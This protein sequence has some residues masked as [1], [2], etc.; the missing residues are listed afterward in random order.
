MTDRSY[1]PR[2][3]GFTLIELLVVIAIIAILAA[4][5]FP[6]FAQAREKARQISCVSNM[7]Q[8]GLAVIQYTQDYDEA[9][10]PAVQYAN[11]GD[12]V[13][14]PVYWSSTTVIGPY[15]KSTAVLQCPDDSFQANKS[16]G[17]YAALKGSRTPVPTS[18]MVNAVT[19]YSDWG[20]SYT[21][22]DL[23]GVMPWGVFPVDAEYPWSTQAN[24]TQASC[25]YPSDL[26]MMV[27]ARE[28]WEEYGGQGSEQNSEEDT[29]WGAGRGAYNT[30][31]YFSMSQV[32]WGLS[33]AILN[34][35][36]PDGKGMTK[37]SGH[38]NI[39]FTDGHVKS[40]VPTQFL[41][42]NGSPDPKNWM[43]DAP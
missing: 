38:T 2:R 9:F 36:Y 31:G 16:S 29:W 7:K 33:D 39:L 15:L 3:S 5:L 43:S 20:Q 12:P 32:Y 23:N 25:H 22:H 6:V 8:V 10:P 4:I 24:I 19:P 18:Y 30:W 35:T 17:A 1:L 14:A 37:H 27:D 40:W 26:V 11:P 41:S 42:N 28:G 34:P 13:G 21:Q